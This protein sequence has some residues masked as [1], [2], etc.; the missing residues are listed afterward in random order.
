M[1]HISDPKRII[2]Q[3]QNNQ[4]VAPRACT[5]T[6]TASGET[7]VCTLP[8]IVQGISPGSYLCVAHAQRDPTAA[9]K[10]KIMQQR[11]R[12]FVQGA[13]A[14]AADPPLTGVAVGPV[15]P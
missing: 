3:V 9:Q 15:P 10:L 14:G 11:Q 7:I 13:G 1:S 8:G 5:A 6:D 4:N 12:G 2:M